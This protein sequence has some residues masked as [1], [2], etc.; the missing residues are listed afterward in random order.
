MVKKGACP[1]KSS[2]ACPFGIPIEV[3]VKN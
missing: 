1:D 3:E 2:K